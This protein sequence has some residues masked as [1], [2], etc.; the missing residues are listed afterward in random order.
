[1]AE[2]RVDKYRIYRESLSKEKTVVSHNNDISIEE[3]EEV[4]FNTTSS[5]PLE[6]VM[7]TIQEQNKQEL[8]FFKKRKQKKILKMA[9][10][11]TIAIVVVALLVILLVIALE[12]K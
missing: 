1:M 7:G 10:I 3:H 9:L 5:L 4:S 12:G 2:T 6:Q 8:E 11:S